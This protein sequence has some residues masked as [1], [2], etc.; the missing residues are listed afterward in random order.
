L[1]AIGRR[2]VLAL[3]LGSLGA[4]GAA[5]AA[6]FLLSPRYTAFA[7]VHV[8]AVPPYI[9]KAWADSPEGKAEF[10]T[11]KRL[12]SAALKNRYVLNSVLKKPDIKRLRIVQ[13]QA[14]PL[15]YF[16]DELKVQNKEGG[17]ILTLSLTGTDADELVDFVRAVVQTYLTD[18]VK[19]EQ[20][21]RKTRLSTLQKVLADEQE[22]LHKKRKSLIDRQGK[23]GDA[24]A[25]RDKQVILQTALAEARR[26]LSLAE[27]ELDQTL[28]RLDT[29]KKIKKKLA[30]QI[31]VSPSDLETALEADGKAQR[32]R[33]K[34]EQWQDYFRKTEEWHVDGNASDVVNA[35]KNVAKY[36]KLLRERR[37][38]LKKAL[39]ERREEKAKQEYDVMLFQLESELPRLEKLKEKWA[40]EVAKLTAEVGKVG[41]P[42]RLPPDQ[43]RLEEEIKNDQGFVNDINLRVS[44]LQVEVA[45]GSRATLYQD[46]GL[47]KVDTKRR[48]IA[49]ALS[50]IAALVGICFAVGWFEC[51]ARKIQ[52]ADE[53]TTALGMRVV[54]AV[55]AVPGPALG[56][57]VTTSDAQDEY[58]SS[59]LESIDAIRTMLLRDASLETTRVLMVSSAVAG[60]GKTTLATN[61]ATSL[62]RAGRK[63]LLVDCDLRCPAAHQLFEQTLQPGVSE[64]L[65]GEVDLVDAI[66]PTTAIDGLWLIPAGQW[67][68]EVIQALARGGAQEM[69]DRLREE[70]DFVVVDSHPI[71]PATDSLLVGQNVDAV[72]LAVM[73]D[74]SQ[75]PRVHA[76]GQRLTSL[77][78]RVLG[79][80]VN[81]MPSEVYENGYE[82]AGQ[83]AR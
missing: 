65:L 29:H 44:T 12:Q 10:E 55:P 5:M 41:G 67:D 82:Y 81:G 40:A 35:R 7:Q 43:I 72:I 78:I 22:K 18:V 2:W 58:E 64:I 69:F 73:R 49:A 68:R 62:A 20:D 34:L 21:E 33:T 11:Y 9:T 4:L 23:A 52:S 80:V 31:K 66:R 46:A 14:E 25:K 32:I 53:L 48:V 1:R 75:V 57:L 13:E 59:L 77:G 51:R 15:T 50:P 36:R 70:F 24:E 8:A 54:G 42:G 47:Q 37:S 56:R 79:A 38:E 30:D 39:L 76:A 27:Q 28:S 60:E 83:V 61:L 45:A 3:C 63:T 74:V 26:S 19:K 71:L 6:W 17:E 16:E